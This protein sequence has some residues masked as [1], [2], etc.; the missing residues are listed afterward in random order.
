MGAARQAAFE[1]AD[2][3]HTDAGPG[4]KFPLGQAAYEPMMPQQRGEVGMRRVRHRA[5]RPMAI[6]SH[7]GAHSFTSPAPTPEPR[8]ME[9]AATAQRPLSC[10]ADDGRV[11][12]ERGAMMAAPDTWR[13]P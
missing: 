2:R 8:G 7:T 10:C 5:T 3:G 11:A 4:G 6:P 1:V 12:R 9:H 13:M